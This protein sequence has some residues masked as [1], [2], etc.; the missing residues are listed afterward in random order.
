MKK[1]LSLILSLFILFS[2]TGCSS[3]EQ[4]SGSV[5]EKKSAG[6]TDGSKTTKEK[7]KNTA[8]SQTDIP[9]KYRLKTNIPDDWYAPLPSSEY[10][11]DFPLF[12]MGG[13]V[14]DAQEGV[15]LP[16]VIDLFTIE[17]LEA[18]LGMIVTVDEDSSS[19]VYDSFKQYYLRETETSIPELW[20]GKVSIWLTDLGNPAGVPHY[21]QSF[22]PDAREIEG[23]GKRALFDDDTVIIHV[24]D[25]VIVG[26]SATFKRPEDRAPEPAKETFLLDFAQFIHERVMDKMA[27]P[28]QAGEKGTNAEITQQHK[29]FKA[30]RAG[31]FEVYVDGFHMLKVIEG[32]V[33]EIYQECSRSINIRPLLDPC[34]KKNTNNSR[35]NDRMCLSRRNVPFMKL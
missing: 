11:I 9:E 2:I 16:E 7:S 22:Y 33:G 25:A 21:L 17:E 24:T 30:L 5:V 28:D 10:S 29:S 13:M 23:L 20:D 31:E 3:K 6:A 19:I 32:F 8:D 15:N 34:L 27:S 26:V 18:Y 14:N 4:S 35:M 12:G 1:V